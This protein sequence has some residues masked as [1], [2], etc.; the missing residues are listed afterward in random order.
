[1]RTIAMLRNE[2]EQEVRHL[3]MTSEIWALLSAAAWAVDAILVRKGT[4]HSNPSTAAFISFLV[5]VAVL[6]PY[7]LFQYPLEK[8]LHPANLH[9]VASGMIQ[10]AMVRLL[11]Y[12]GIVR[13][14]VSRAGP[15]RGTAPLF[16]MIVAFFVLGEM[17]GLL[18]YGGACLTVAGTWLVSYKRVGEKKWRTLDLLF[19]LGAAML[20]SVSQNIRKL[21]LIVTGEPLLSS[22]V[23]TATS[24]L[25]LAGSLVVTGKAHTLKFTKECLPYYLGAAVFALVGQLLTFNALHSGQ[26]SVV[27]PIINTTPLFIIGFTALFLRGEE[28][29]TKMVVIG[30]VLLVAGIAVITAR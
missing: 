22:T 7:V 6:V 11:F 26:V 15:V 23:S 4:A 18:V 20:A 16:S 24:F 17:P 10:P 13:L 28:K 30:V 3:N 1:M 25:C 8:I 9:F 5:S 2:S 21:G 27:S 19:P 29:I 12:M 14:G